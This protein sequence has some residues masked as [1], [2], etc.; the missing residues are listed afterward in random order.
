M[1]AFSLIGVTVVSA[2]VATA[3][4]TDM[5]IHNR[6]RRNEWFAEQQAKSA[7][8]L[9]E[10]KR[11]LSVGGATEDQVLL[12]NRERAADAAEEAKK[13]RP[14]VFKRTTNWLF[15]GLSQEEQKGGRLGAANASLQPVTEEILG[16]QHDRSV[17]QAA[18]EKLESHRR[19]GEKLEEVVR[20]RGGPLDRQ[21][22]HTIDVVAD[23]SKGWFSWL[24]R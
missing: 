9:A 17:L 10:A 18:E 11:A 16:Q 14:G 23:T 15:S 12:I 22:Q 20:P 4:I 8:E 6:K 5:M 1:T 13:N 19:Q 2:V 3:G 7:K 24:Q 21:A